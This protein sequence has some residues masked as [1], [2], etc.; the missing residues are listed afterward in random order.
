MEISVTRGDLWTCVTASP[1]EIEASAF[2]RGVIDILVGK[3]PVIMNVT[4]LPQP[5][6]KATAEAVA[7]ATSKSRKDAVDYGKVRALYNARWPVSKIADEVRCSE[8]SVR[9]YLKKEGLINEATTA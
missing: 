7:K 3:P 4:G 5:D 1:E 8:Q 6:P 2:I 9:N